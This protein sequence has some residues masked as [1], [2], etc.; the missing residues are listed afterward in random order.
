MFN[1]YYRTI[2]ISG[3]IYDAKNTDRTVQSVLVLED[4]KI[5]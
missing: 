4:M 1:E 3:N 5:F 2:C